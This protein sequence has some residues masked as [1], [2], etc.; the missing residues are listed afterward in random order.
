MSGTRP[1]PDTAARR[2]RPPGGTG[3][4]PGPRPGDEGLDHYGMAMADPEANE[5]DIA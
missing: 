1:V 2:S 3:R 4:H 5:F